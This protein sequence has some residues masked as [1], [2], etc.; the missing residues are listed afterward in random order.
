MPP[1]ANRHTPSGLSL[2]LPRKLGPFPLV[3]AAVTS[4]RTGRIAR[5]HR[6]A[7]R[8]NLVNARRQL[9][10]VDGQFEMNWGHLRRG[11]A[12]NAETMRSRIV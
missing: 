2:P 3:P 4:A 12:V 5:K 1:L 7:K 8:V 9:A 6:N 11:I 10:A